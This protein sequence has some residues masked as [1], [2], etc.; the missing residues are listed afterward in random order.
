VPHETR[1]HVDAENM[2]LSIQGAESRSL[3]L[4][5]DGWLGLAIEHAKHL[6]QP[7]DADRHI[8]EAATVVLP[9]CAEMARRFSHEPKKQRVLRVTARAHRFEKPLRSRAVVEDEDSTEFGD[10]IDGKGALGVLCR[11]FV[12]QDLQAWDDVVEND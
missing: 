12:M 9:Q 5:V 8:D 1:N 11:K 7:R 3:T 6:L 2:P 4:V 10:V